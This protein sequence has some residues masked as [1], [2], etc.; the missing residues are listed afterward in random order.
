MEESASPSRRSFNLIAF[1]I[2]SLVV[3]ALV[4]VS[5]RTWEQ[6]RRA[7][8]EAARSR[9]ILAAIDSV[10]AA[11]V[12][13]ESGQRGFLLTGESRYLDPFNRAVEELPNDLATLRELLG[14]SQEGMREFDE[15][16]SLANQKEG[17]L[18]QTIELRR[19]QG[20]QAALA[21]VL[22]GE[23]KRTMEAIRAVCDQMRRNEDARKGRAS[24]EGEA[25]SGVALLMTVAG[26]L[27]L[28]FVF[29]FGLEP[30]AGQDPEAWRRPRLI[31]YGAA[32]LAVVAITLLRGALTP[33]IG[34]TNF[35]FTMYF[36]AV[37]FA[38]W[39]G[40]FRP[41]VL[42]MLLSLLAGSWFFAAP[43][44]SLLV[45]GRD[46][47]VAMLMM[48]LVGLGA[49]LLSRSQ[50]EAVERAMRAESAERIERQRFKTTLTSIGDAVIATDRDGM[51]TFLNSQAEK[52]TGLNAQQA[53]GR[54][55]KQVF[56]IL[57]EL[58]GEEAEDPVRKVMELGEVVGLANHTVL[59]D[60]EGNLIPIE[61]SAAPIRDE[62]GD[63][64]GV[65]LVFR[66]V[67]TERKT[68]EMM[69]KT[70]KLAAA[71]RLSATVAHE[72]NNPLAAVVNLV[73][74]AK[75]MRGMPADAIQQLTLAEQEL[76]RIA[77][78]TRQAL[79]FYR[80]SA[81][82]ENIDVGALIDS[83][84]KLY[85]NKIAAK[86]VRVERF[87]DPCPP[88]LGVAG[89]L[90]QAASNLI[91]NAIDAVE[92]GGSITIRAYPPPGSDQNRVEVIITDNG[93][94]IPH[95]NLERIF[96]PFFTTKKDVG[97][98]LGLWAAKTIVERH[99]GSITAKNGDSLQGSRGATF[100]IQLPCAGGRGANGAG[101][102]S[103]G[104][105][106]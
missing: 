38:A 6:Y 29:A 80:E 47:Q 41:A 101:N 12:D 3:L 106:S 78:I 56:R 87:Y 59:K 64:N 98:G 14:G 102:T 39:F 100:V 103:T 95:E 93:P 45:H 34:R 25:A 73:F 70:E 7:N 44:R 27:V 15:L 13:A 43:T 97:T 57:S 53:Q 22:T 32:V 66:D 21:I 104:G 76:D 96:E 89:E 69:R 61:D 40:G 2:A 55:I 65:V 46:D 8:A 75:N 74:I 68:Q 51:V 88:I 58:T 99:G 60:R 4:G 83:V 49:G 84:L 42:S 17:E 5:F 16:N 31:R 35:P 26:A 28:L 52:L 91:A 79:G 37:I 30:F 94:G 11:L 50:R 62:R 18:R 105:S 36:C 19:T 92:P 82:P 71:A 1:G 81:A 48:V 67:T 20:A 54:S 10:Q 77:H 23:G 33:L 63:L 9:G 85:S 86:G 90:R 24:A 72:I